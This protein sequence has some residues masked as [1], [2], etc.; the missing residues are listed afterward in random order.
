MII[1]SFLFSL[2]S[3]QFPFPMLLDNE[4]RIG[5]TH[6]LSSHV[7][8]QIRWR[9]PRDSLLFHY[10]EP[11]IGHTI[12]MS[13]CHILWKRFVLSDLGWWA[14]WSDQCL[15]PLEDE[16]K[17]CMWRMNI[18]TDGEGTSI[19]YKGAGGICFAYD[20]TGLSHGLKYNTK[21]A[22][23]FLPCE[24]IQATGVR[25]LHDLVAADWF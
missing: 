8:C 9:E 18:I 5:G 7:R 3:L 24:G 17:Y 14:Y 1:Q 16:I 11:I 19:R 15:R 6:I 4:I 13:T 21:A 12:L 25:D 2:S 20:M 22:T 23:T 10:F